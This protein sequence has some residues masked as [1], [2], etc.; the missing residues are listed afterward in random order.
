MYCLTLWNTRS[1]VALFWVFGISVSIA[2]ST[3]IE[4]VG[5]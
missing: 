4:C 3:F 5:I 2:F 1:F